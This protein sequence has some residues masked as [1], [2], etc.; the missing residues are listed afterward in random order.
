[1]LTSHQHFHFFGP[2]RNIFPVIS[3]CR[4]LIR[5][6]TGRLKMAVCMS[7][8]SP[9]VGVAPGHCVNGKCALLSSGVISHHF[10]SLSLKCFS[11]CMNSLMTLH[12]SQCVDYRSSMQMIAYVFMMLTP[13]VELRLI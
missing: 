11:H 7:S 13:S 9:S 6:Q 5:Q 2:S 10:Y 4:L 1:M 3:T 12:L 8:G